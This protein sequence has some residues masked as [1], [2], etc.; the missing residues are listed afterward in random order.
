M[1]THP[2]Y[3]EEE[4]RQKVEK[5]E[6]MFKQGV[7]QAKVAG[8]LRISLKTLYAWLEKYG[9]GRP[10][11]AARTKPK[12]EA[13]AKSESA[14]TGPVRY[15]PEQKAQMRTRALE[16]RRQGKSQRAIAGELG[17]ANKTARR[18]LRE[19]VPVTKTPRPKGV[20]RP[21][22]GT[23]ARDQVQDLASMLDRMR[24]IDEQVNTLEAERNSLRETALR[25]HKAIGQEL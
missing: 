9:S 6:K 3:P 5:A 16:L 18:L 20:A 15:T 24:V 17:V 21:K 10:G 12:T 4:R 8:E 23:A 11:K 14:R 22:A 19:V 2:P 1:A 13:K 25:L 7:S